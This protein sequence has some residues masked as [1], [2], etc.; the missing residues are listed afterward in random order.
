MITV[1]EAK[2]LIAAHC[3]RPAPVVM[4]LKEAYGLVL[5]EDVYAK[6]SVPNFNQSAMD[7]YAFRYE[8]YLQSRALHITGEVAAGD[9]ADK[10]LRAFDAVRIFTGAPVPSGADTVVMQEK[11]SVENGQLII[12]DDE[13]QQGTN[14][15]LQGADKKKDDVALKAGT[16]LSPA[17]IG[18]LAGVGISEVM[19]YRKPIVHIIVTGKELQQQGKALQHGQVYESNSIMLESALRQLNIN[20]ITSSFADD[21]PGEI[22]ALLVSALAEADIVLLSGGVSVGD[23]DFVVNA[24]TASGVAQLFHKVQQRPG[25]PLYAGTKDDKIVFGLPG[26]PS[27]VLSCFYNYVLVAIEK[28]TGLS[29][30]IKKKYLPLTTTHTKKTNL[31]HFL[32]GIYNDFGVTPLGAQESFRL[33]SFSIANCLIVLPE[34]KTDFAAGEIVETLVL[35]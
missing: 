30:I 15:R 10:H 28:M 9:N 6:A 29:N 27:S 25:K 8:D 32:K 3:T 16:T 31:K 17:A 1:D 14:V 7:G 11:T 23:Y 12:H 5:A 13:L 22:Q 26:N 24:A 35:P 33:S 4:P 20:N 18:F 21:N 2:Q 19:V 34:D